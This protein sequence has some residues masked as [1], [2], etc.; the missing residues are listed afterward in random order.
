MFALLLAGQFPFSPAR[1]RLLHE[2]TCHVYVSSVLSLQLVCCRKVLLH[3]VVT[4]RPP[5]KVFVLIHMIGFL[6]LRFS[7]SPHKET[8]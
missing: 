8:C 5:G 4:P 2:N 1:L 7:F 6:P 3:T